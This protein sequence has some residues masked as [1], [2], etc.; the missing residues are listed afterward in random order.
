M[1]CCFQVIFSISFGRKFCCNF[2]TIRL[3][4]TKKLSGDLK[5]IKIQTLL[6]LCHKMYYEVKVQTTN[7]FFLK[8]NQIT[9]LK[10]K[11]KTYFFNEIYRMEREKKKTYRQKKL[12][13]VLTPIQFLGRGMN[14]CLWVYQ[15][16]RGRSRSTLSWLK[17]EKNNKITR[18]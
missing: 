15:C 7:Y 3:S 6:D 10:K 4:A 12:I 13:Y 11:K 17:R 16:C 18:A 1:Q 14:L 2:E 9:Q 5:K 8:K